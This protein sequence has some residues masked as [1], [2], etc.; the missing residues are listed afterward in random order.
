MIIIITITTMA[1]ARVDAAVAPR[2]A[3]AAVPRNT[4]VI[5][6]VAVPR[7]GRTSTT[8]VAARKVPRARDP[9]TSPT[10]MTMTVGRGHAVEAVPAAVTNTTT[11][12]E[13]TM[14]VETSHRK[15]PAT[16]STITTE[17]TMM[18]ERKEARALAMTNTTMMTEKAEKDR[19]EAKVASH[20]KVARVT[21][22]KSPSH[23]PSQ[24]AIHSENQAPNPW[25]TQ[26]ASQARNQSKSSLRPHRQSTMRPRRIQPRRHTTFPLHLCH[27]QIPLQSSLL[28]FHRHMLQPLNI[29]RKMDPQPALPQLHLP[30]ICHLH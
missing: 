26:L 8:E 7:V 25:N 22:A 23:I 12:K 6:A 11:P 21:A 13:M 24:Q 29:L 30:L 20:P 9:T 15:A 14:M 2:A 27:N 28:R 10:E 18:V 16:T 4:T 3:R 19:N 17:T 1:K 5:A